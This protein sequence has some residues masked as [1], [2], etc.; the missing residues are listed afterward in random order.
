MTTLNK[1][2]QRFL[3]GESDARGNDGKGAFAILNGGSF[4][5]SV[6]MPGSGINATDIRLFMAL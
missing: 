3:R 1:T 6:F 5:P 4:S 2:S